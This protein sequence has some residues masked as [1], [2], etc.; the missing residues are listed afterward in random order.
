MNA[1]PVYYLNI[2]TK[3][4]LKKYYMPF[5]KE[6]A[7]FIPTQ[8]ELELNTQI[9]LNLKIPGETE[10]FLIEGPVVWINPAY[11]QSGRSQGVGIRFQNKEAKTVREKIEKS[12]VNLD[13]TGSHSETL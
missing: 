12:L 13:S 7:I 2:E 3:A 6:G 1:L 5:I 11:A 10:T 4:Q 9:K 8:D